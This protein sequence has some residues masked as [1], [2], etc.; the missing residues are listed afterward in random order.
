MS[1]EVAAELWGELRRYVNTVD[2]DEAAE[3]VVAV[4]IDNDYDADQ[5][6]D[7]FKGDS[8][9]KRALAAY[10]N[11]DVEEEPDE[12]VDDDVDLDDDERWE[13]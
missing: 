2:R 9:I 4:L 12:E 8:D 13:N 5:I 11:R 10:V 7:A 3:I 1:A 6:R